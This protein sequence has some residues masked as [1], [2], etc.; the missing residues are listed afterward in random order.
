MNIAHDAGLY[1]LCPASILFRVPLEPR[2]LL[3]LT[4]SISSGCVLPKS[5]PLYATYSSPISAYNFT[6]LLDFPT[7]NG[8]RLN[9]SSLA[10]PNFATSYTLGSIGEVDGSLSYLYSSLTLNIPSK[11]TAIPLR[12]IVQGY[13]QLLELRRPEEPWW[14]ELWHQGKRIDRK[15]TL[16]YGRLYLPTSTLEALYLHRLSPTTQLKIACVS[17]SSLKSGGSILVLLQRDV[18]KYSSEFLYS[19]DSALLG[20]RGLYNF[21]PDPRAPSPDPSPLT[22]NPLTT[23]ESK[24]SPST[25]LKG[26]F[27]AGAEVYYGLLNKSGGMSTG[28][29]FATLPSHTGFPYT[30]TLTVNPLMGN[31]SSTYAVKAGRSLALCSRFDFNVY[32]YESELQVGIEL[33]RRRRS[34][35]QDLSWVRTKL[36]K[37][38]GWDQDVLA[39]T[40]GEK[41]ASGEEDEDA[42]TAGVLKARVNQDWGIRFLWEG[43]IKELLYTAGLVVDLKKREQIFRGVGLEVQY[44]S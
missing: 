44:S 16:L 2:Q 38:A 20:V 14:W 12:S 6:A 30:M 28:I 42:N 15:D 25:G 3:R 24:D 40:L 32:S 39:E 7:P 10:S 37:S 9:L 26:R 22:T 4:D 5:C 18:G 41:G 36:Q 8:L 43:K 33:W 21:G 31:L 35:G 17:S 29:R 19:T 23:P 34:Q 11:S 1:G 13:R 27:S